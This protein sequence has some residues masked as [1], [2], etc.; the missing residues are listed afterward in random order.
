MHTQGVLFEA[1]F[2]RAEYDARYARAR[3][4]MEELDIDALLLSLGIHIRY[5]AGYRT[6]FWGDAPGMPLVLV[7]RD[8]AMV[9]TLIL[10][11]YMQ[12]T[13]G[14]S[15]IEDVRY[16]SPER[17]A[18][19][20]DP[21][22]LAADV[23][24]SHGLA[25]G[26]I[27]MD[28]GNSVRDNM[29]VIGFDRLRAAL[30]GVHVVDAE[31]VTSPL[32]QIKSAAEIDVLRRV[33]RTTCAAWQAG[34]EALHEGMSEKQLAATVC[35][36]ILAI[37]EEAGLIR[38][39]ALYMASGRDMAVWCNVLPSPYRLQRGDL[40][41]ID[42]GAICKGYHADIIRWG[43]IG[44][45]PDEDQYLMDVATEAN[46]ACRSAIKAGVPCAE[47]HRIGAEVYRRS[48]IDHD[49]WKSFGPA[50]HGVGLDVH[51]A[52]F[53]IPTNEMP[54]KAGMVITVEPLI[55]KTRAGRYAADSAQRYEGRA[56]DM[57]AVED[58]VLVTEAGYELLTQ[59]QPYIWRSR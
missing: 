31:T 27:A 29:P 2:P 56:P 5:L 21:C 40:V 19:F 36:A 26:S 55:V 42:G 48:R 50:G 38:P 39:W 35:S 45:L 3:Q 33:C 41:L 25:R 51:E 13:A 16:V 46:A 23:V 9:P 37:G 24:K 4:V 54:L 12:F 8:P 34:L 57:C 11:R 30:P 6:P 58:N 10:S 20:N 7:P 49:D 1:D 22:D 32:R 44:Q 53:L 17:P 52:P 18:P 59:L 28:V 14:T 15:W 47:I 43:A